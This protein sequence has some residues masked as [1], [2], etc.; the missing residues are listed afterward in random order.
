MAMLVNRI[1][2]PL[3]IN[4]PFLHET[5]LAMNVTTYLKVWVI[6]GKRCKPKP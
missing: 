4:V 3:P 5:K 2:N 6:L 1:D